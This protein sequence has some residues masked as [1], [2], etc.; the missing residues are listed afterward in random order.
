MLLP[1]RLTV[2]AWPLVRPMLRPPLLL[3]VAAVIIMVILNA[4]RVLFFLRE[5]ALQ[6]AARLAPCT[7]CSNSKCSL[8]RYA[9]AV[10]LLP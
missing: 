5:V 4:A 3:T 7:L 9:Q 2:S 8:Q 6:T 1:T 10:L